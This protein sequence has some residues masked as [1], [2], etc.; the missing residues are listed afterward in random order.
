MKTVT[1]ANKS[2][3]LELPVT[4]SLDGSNLINETVYQIISD[5][6]VVVQS[7]N[8]SSKKDATVV[9]DGNWLDFDVPKQIGL[10]APPAKKN[11]F[12]RSQKWIGHILRINEDN[13]FSAK[14]ED[15]NDLTT[16]EYAEF[17]LLE[18]SPDDHELLDVGSVFYWSVGYE[19]KNGTVRKA[20]VLKF[21]RLPI[22]DDAEIKRRIAL[23]DDVV[24]NVDQLIKKISWE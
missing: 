5:Q 20:S 14:L 16:N 8:D 19:N 4:K 7:S 10:F 11:Y 23:I 12:N 1:E 13:T 22:V 21:Q 17:S 18:V 24:D 3:I 2:S 9:N 15:L 6:I